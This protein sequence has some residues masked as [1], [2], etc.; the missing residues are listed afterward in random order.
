MWHVV[1]GSFPT[2]EAALSYVQRKGLDKQQL[3]VRFVDK[4]KT[5]R[6][7][8]SSF[9]DQDAAGAARDAIKDRFPRAWIIQF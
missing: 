8:H 5:Y 7:I 3:V 9:S 4:L 6:L 1:L 2:E